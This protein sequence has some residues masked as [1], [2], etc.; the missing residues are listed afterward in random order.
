MK[1]LLCASALAA[2]VLGALA[3]LSAQQ[4]APADPMFQAMRDEIDRARKLTIPNLEAPY[5]IEYSVDEEESFALSASLG[6]LLMRRKDRFRSPDVHIRVGDY[7]FDNG[8]YAGGGF[9]GSRYD[10]ARFPLEDSYPLL[11]RY[12]WLLADS[13]YKSSVEAISRKR[14]A[15]RNMQQGEQ[16]ADFAHA[17]PVKSVRPIKRLTLDEDLW[18]GRVRSLSAIFTEFP[19][20][21]N[22]AVEMETS[23]GGLHLVNSEGTEAREPESVALLRAR[24]LAQAPDGMSLRDAVTFHAHDAG[25]LPAEAELRRGITEMAAN[26][27]ALSK[28]P[29]GE[30]YSGPVLFEGAAGAQIFAEVLARNLSLSRRP[31]AEGGRGGNVQASELDGRMGARVLPDTFDVVDD[32]TQTEWRGRPLFGSYKVDREGVVPKPLRLI[33][34]GVLKSYLLTRQPV[35][36][37]EGSN[38]RARL[39]GNMGA[40]SAT[41]SNLF[42]STSDAVPVSELK[43]KLIE[44]IRTR[45]KPYGI[46]VRKMD[47][48]STASLP[49]ARALMSGQQTGRPV[50][51]PVLVYKVFPDGHE[52]LVRGMRFRGFNVRSLKD[53][54]AAGDDASAFEYMDNVAP[55]ALV[56]GAGFTAEVCVVA[57]SILIDDLELHPAEEELPKLP[58]V[59]PPDMT[60]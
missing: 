14:A 15:M 42:V 30:D 54:L 17:E 11:R 48:P 34:K 10:L 31:V 26:V 38:G 33:E 37:F 8:N 7:K 53:I 59:S 57:P 12:F 60:R 5:F 20:I 44:L 23:E 52:E 56:G 35:R 29:K 21:K 13:A 25:H 36:G 45:N 22:S 50:S 9:G 3:T 1:R 55:F 39:P 41:I 51:M 40:N 46:I 27:V 16:I 6:G 32:P 19:D 18:A 2:A 24:A 4:A 47:F 28:A 58:V 43:K 49:E